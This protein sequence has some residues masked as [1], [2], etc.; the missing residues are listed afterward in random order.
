MGI[1]IGTNMNFTIR[2]IIQF[3]QLPLSISYDL[4]II[5]VRNK[6]QLM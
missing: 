1:S 4:K 6:Y 5:N 3:Y 2:I